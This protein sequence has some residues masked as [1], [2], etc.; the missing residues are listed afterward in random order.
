MSLYSR[1]YDALSAEECFGNEASV[2][3]LFKTAIDDAEKDSVWLSYLENAGVDN[4]SGI[5]YAQELYEADE[6][7]T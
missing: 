4:W 6:E 5:D 7:T 3:A 2:L 1:L